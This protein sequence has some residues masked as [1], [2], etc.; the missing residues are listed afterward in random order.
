MESIDKRIKTKVTMMQRLKREKY[1]RK[2]EGT[3]KV[4]YR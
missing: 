2:E 4:G 3:T 1:T